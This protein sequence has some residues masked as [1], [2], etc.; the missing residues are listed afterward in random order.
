MPRFVGH[1]N[2]KIDAWGRAGP[3]LRRPRR[4]RPAPALRRGDHRRE[5]YL[6]CAKAFL[7]SELWQPDSWA[8]RD[9]ARLS[10]EVAAIE[11][12]LAEGYRTTLY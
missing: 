10:A 3:V 11:A 8:E 4:R 7:R 6:H 12:N 5:G 1:H 9:H 2:C